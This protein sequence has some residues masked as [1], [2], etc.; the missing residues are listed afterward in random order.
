[1]LQQRFAQFIKITIMVTIRRERK[2]CGRAKKRSRTTAYWKVTK[3]SARSK[4]PH[5][6][7]A[8]MAYT[9]IIAIGWCRENGIPRIF[10]RRYGSAF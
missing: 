7:C 1:M 2:A 8:G 6:F 4:M 10:F 9:R 5:M 3:G